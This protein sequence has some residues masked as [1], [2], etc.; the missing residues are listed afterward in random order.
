M[1]KE[2]IGINGI[3]MW[4]EGHI[5]C[6]YIYGNSMVNKV[7]FCWKYLNSF[8]ISYDWEKLT[9]VGIKPLS[10]IPDGKCLNYL[11]HQGIL[12]VATLNPKGYQPDSLDHH[13]G[14]SLNLD[15]IVFFWPVYAIRLGL[16]IDYSISAMGHIFAICP[17][18]FLGAY[19]NNVK[20][21]YSSAYDH[22]VGHS[23][24]IWYIYILKY[25]SEMCTWSNWLVS[26]ICG[27][28]GAYLFLGHI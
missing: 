28:W 24:F 14:H 26:Y 15:F 12:P 4:F 9:Q 17:V 2:V 18:Y 11:D 16:H 19:A 8:N 5:C 27:I 25:S 10:H 3:C 6:W 7:R 13:C 20:L 21:M 1:S 22:I 23:K